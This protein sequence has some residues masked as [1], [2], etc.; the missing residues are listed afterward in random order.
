M[1]RGLVLG[2]LLACICAP[3]RAEIA[4]DTQ[5]LQLT[6]SPF[7]DLLSVTACLPTCA[8]PGARR[9]AFSSF[10]GFVSLNRNS[11]S[12]FELHRR[13]G[14]HS[15]ELVFTNRVSGERRRWRIPHHGYQIGLEVAQAQG[16]VLTSGEEF[17]PRDAAGF[18]RWLESLRYVRVAEG[19]VSQHGQDEQLAPVNARQ[20]WLGFRNRF[21]AAMLR[22]EQSEQGH[23]STPGNNAEL[24]WNL[25]GPDTAAARYAIYAGP[26]DP[27]ALAA[28]DPQLRA[29][30]FAGLWSPLRWL[31]LGFYQA[32]LAI[33]GLLGHWGASIILLSFAVQ[34]LMFPL[35]RYAERLQENV[36]DTE[37]R[38]APLIREI[39]QESRGAEQAERIMALYR[40]HGVHPLY[41]LKSMLGLLFLVPVFIAAFNMLAENP[42]LAGQSFLWITDLSRPDTVA[43]L[44]FALPFLGSGLNL[45]PFVMTALNLLATGLQHRDVADAMA[46]RRL[47]RRAGVLSF[48]FLLLFYTFPAGMVLY[49]TVNNVAAVLARIFRQSPG[50][51]SR[52]G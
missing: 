3:V 12:A 7:G 8:E 34:L 20:Q 31:S 46:R 49:W 24:Q 35:N 33:H 39:R 16:L 44:P 28:A 21:W 43:R 17:Q 9:Q 10:R 25:A 42:W 29:M 4:V 50:D 26:V 40:A 37:I 6:F 48:A 18:A 15:I 38:L 52:D 23:V 22:A 45:L 41:S 13:N 27:D 19:V 47:N 5:S 30:A 32:L 14:E 51:F 36:R 2:L 1:K 11:N